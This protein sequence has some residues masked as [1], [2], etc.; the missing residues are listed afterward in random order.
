[1]T[2]ATVDQ[3]YAEAAEKAKANP[4]GRVLA[5]VILAVFT[6]IGYVLGVFWT[7]LWFSGMALAYGVRQGSRV[8]AR[9]APESALSP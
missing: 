3:L 6:G 4:P 1:M 9:P 7:A 8:P 2:T 5:T